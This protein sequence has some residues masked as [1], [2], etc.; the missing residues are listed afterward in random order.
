MPLKSVVQYI[1]A[2]NRKFYLCSKVLIIVVQVDF[3][4]STIFYKLKNEKERE[5]RCSEEFLKLNEQNN[6]QHESQKQDIL[7][8]VPCQTFKL[9]YIGY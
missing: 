2:R 3:L 1:N 9:L 7:R 4:Q 8:L 6:H 5:T